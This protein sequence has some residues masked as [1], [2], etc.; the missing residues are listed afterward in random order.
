MHAR[1]ANNRHFL[2]RTDR[3]ARTIEEN[4][5]TTKFLSISG[6][7]SMLDRGVNGIYCTRTKTGI[8]R[9]PAKD[10]PA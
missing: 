2:L 7:K 1:N 4:R 8:R 3:V 9:M 10:K 6:E 5:L